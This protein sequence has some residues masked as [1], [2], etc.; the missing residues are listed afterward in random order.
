MLRIV[1][2]NVFKYVNLITHLTVKVDF[3][4]GVTVEINL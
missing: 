4:C 1:S 3:H 2:L